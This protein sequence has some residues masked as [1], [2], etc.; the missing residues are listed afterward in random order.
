MIQLISADPTGLQ[1]KNE[2]LRALEDPELLGVGYGGWGELGLMVRQLDNAYDVVMVT[3]KGVKFGMNPT[4]ENGLSFEREIAETFLTNFGG[5]PGIAFV[6]SVKGL[7]KAIGQENIGWGVARL[8]EPAFRTR[9]LKEAIRHQK[10]LGKIQREG[11]QRLLEKDLKRI[12][13][14][15]LSR[16]TTCVE[17]VV[18][19]PEEFTSEP[20]EEDAAWFWSWP[21]PTQGPSKFP[22]SVHSRFR[23]SRY[24]RN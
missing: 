5:L 3:T 23:P 17:E 18:C 24:P 11:A 21:L 13:D 22:M 8:I 19:R 15:F 14:E 2:F 10:W 4:L 1:P 9:E 7:E 6:F 16:T 20:S 12:N